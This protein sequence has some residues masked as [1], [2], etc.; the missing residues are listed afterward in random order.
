MALIK[1]GLIGTEL[2]YLQY[3]FYAEQTSGSVNNRTIKITLKAK[4]N[5]GYYG[6]PVNWRA[7]ING[8]WSSWM[9]LKGTE[10][11]SVNDGFRTFTYTATT[12][13]GTTSS[14]SITV[15]FG[16]D[17]YGGD[18]TWDATISGSFSVGATNRNP[19]PPY[20]IIIR[21]GNSSSSPVLSAGIVAENIN[22]LYI[23]WNPG[24]DPDGD[25]L[26]YA[27]NES[28]NGGGYTQVDF[29]TDTAHSYTV[30]GWNEGETLQYYVDAKDTNGAWST[31]VY[32]GVLTKNKMT[33]GYFTGHS[34]NIDFNTKSFELRFT[35]GENTN[36]TAVS[37]SCYSD[38][39]TIYN[40]TYTSNS[41]QTIL[42]WR[43]GDSTPA[44]NQPYIKFTDLINAYK[45]SNY[46]G[47]LH[48]GLRTKNNYGTVKTAG[49][50]INVDIRV[51]PTEPSSVNITGGSAKKTIAGSSIYLPNGK[52]NI[53]FSWGKSSN[54]LGASFSYDLYEVYNG[55]EVKLANV[56]SSV[57]SYSIV[58]PE[59]SNSTATLAFKVVAVT[60]YGYTANKKSS[61]ITLEYY[62]QP[63]ISIGDIVRTETTASVN[64]SIKTATSI[65]TVQGSA[66]WE[67]SN[68][69]KGSIAGSG[70]IK[71]SNLNESSTYSIT[72]LYNDNSGLSTSKT[73]LISIGKNLP[74]VDINSYGIG[75]GGY[76]ANTNNALYVKGNAKIDGILYDSTGRVYTTGYKPTPSDIGAA[77]SSHTHSYLPLSGG[78]LTG[79]LI[80]GSGVKLEN[81]KLQSGNCLRIN[82]GQGTI[83][84]GPQNS[85][86][87]HFNTSSPMFYFYKGICLGGGEG[88]GTVIRGETGNRN[89]QSL[90]FYRAGNRARFGV[91]TD[92]ALNGLDSFPCIEQWNANG[93]GYNV[94]LEVKGDRLRYLKGNNAM[95]VWVDSGSHGGIAIGT[96]A[97]TYLKWLRGATQL[98]VRNYADNAYTQIVASAFTVGSSEKYKTNINELDYSI[99]EN[100]VMNNT[101]R[102]Y[103]LKE[104]IREINNII[105]ESK[106][107]DFEL[108]LD[109]ITPNTKAGIIIEDL[110]EEA[111]E[112]LRPERTDGIDVYAMVSVLWRFCQEQKKEIDIL[113][114]KLNV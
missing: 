9:K 63:T 100:I 105:E 45:S 98:Q 91:G 2:P 86:W 93:T 95:N 27:L 34:N 8:T 61:S 32:S 6:F 92:G 101:I 58:R 87:C 82:T 59:Q 5:T 50:S 51:S 54:A 28:K 69:E 96:S 24:S 13:V 112:I 71:I 65:K 109:M 40:Q 43:T 88:D 26:T 22:T 53:T 1:S 104:E 31:K 42:I 79:S 77:Q 75:I 25:K 11:W 55:V 85:S 89:W 57:S 49:G 17:S 4:L 83:D 33:A 35:G 107:L 21:N 39:V 70:A 47:K 68:G 97:T 15:G 37:Y 99:A 81:Q 10:S 3:E 19:N 12:N 114:Q 52:D 20:N 76:S 102:T 90:D 30:S 16:I 38:T 14:K 78:A 110:T 29:G 64:V 60:S 23:S 111:K 41:T 18:E 67:G 106:S 80:I 113:K 66:T 56:D 84:I 7:N 36:K 48:V 73:E 108:D 103:Q 46:N 74:I 44:S 94:R 72:I 62:K